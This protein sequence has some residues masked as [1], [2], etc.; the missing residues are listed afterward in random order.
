M[1]FLV[2]LCQQAAIKVLLTTVYLNDVNKFPISSEGQPTKQR[3]DKGFARNVESVCIV[4]VVSRTLAA[5][6][7]SF[8]LPIHR[9]HIE[10]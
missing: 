10:V 7:C 5:Y 9:Q 2:V 1:F 3:P 6:R 8:P 4:Q